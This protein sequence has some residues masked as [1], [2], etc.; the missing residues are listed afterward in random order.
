MLHDGG[1]CGSFRV[2][3]WIRGGC[4]IVEISDGLVGVVLL[5]ALGAQAMM[6]MLESRGHITN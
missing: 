3:R 5:N 4:G 6:F 2:W 1:F